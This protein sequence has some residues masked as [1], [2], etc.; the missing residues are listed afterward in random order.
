MNRA[1][2]VSLHNPTTIFIFAKRFIIHWNLGHVQR[3]IEIYCL[4]GIMM[5]IGSGLLLCLY[6]T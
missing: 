4:I 5:G 6:A 3:V 2:S 1:L